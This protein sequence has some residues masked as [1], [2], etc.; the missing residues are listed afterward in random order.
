MNPR[1]STPFALFETR[2][3]TLPKRYGVKGTAWFTAI[4]LFICYGLSLAVY[5]T[6]EFGPLYLD[7]AFVGIGAAVALLF[8]L[9]PTARMAYILTLVS[10][11]G[12][13]T[14]ICLAVI[15]GSL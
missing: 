3:Q 2:V 10:M 5:L 1:F 13:G 8:V 15:L 7:L 6:G 4:C 12:P 14:L 9:R 11:M